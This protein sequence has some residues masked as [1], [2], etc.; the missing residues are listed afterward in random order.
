M[1][2]CGTL[3]DTKP[4]PLDEELELPMEGNV[5][6]PSNVSVTGITKR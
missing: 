4:W 6:T 5:T 1:Y 3:V 2:S